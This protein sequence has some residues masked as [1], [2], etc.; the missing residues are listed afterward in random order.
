MA[1]VFVNPGVVAIFSF[2]KSLSSVLTAL[3]ETGKG[4]EGVGGGGVG[5][6]LHKSAENQADKTGELR[7]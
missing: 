5:V 3:I 4:K 7:K 6:G 1:G 2:L